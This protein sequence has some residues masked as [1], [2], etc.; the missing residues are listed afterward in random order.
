VIAAQLDAG[1]DSGSAFR[2]AFAGWLGLAPGDLGKDGLLRATTLDTPLG[3]MIAVSDTSALHLLEFTDRAALPGE[4]HRLATQ[5]KGSI[6]IGRYP[7]TDQVESELANFFA[8]QS[9]RFTT[10]LAFHGTAFTQRVWRALCDIPAGQTRS[11]GAL[12]QTIG[13]PTAARAVARANGANQIAIV[14]P[15]HRVIGADGT[16][17]GYGGG[18]WRKSRL[19]AI[20]Q[21]FQKGNDP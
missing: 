17:T 21:H 13:Q 8:G 18:L 12:A 7:P 14:V 9:A 10:P 2:L 20:E 19:L 5:A 11:Y 3:P 6:G 15:C 1:Y 4:M 16:L